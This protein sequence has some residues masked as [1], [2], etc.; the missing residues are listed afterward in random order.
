MLEFVLGIAQ[1]VLADVIRDMI[2]GKLSTAG[3]TEIEK[4]VAHRLL[5]LARDQH[6]SDLEEM[7]RE[8]LSEIDIISA[9]DPD[10][11]VA[12]DGIRLA[13]PPK[14]PLLRRNS[15]ERA[16]TELMIRLRSLSEVVARRREEI[17]ISVK[18][19]AEDPAPGSGP[20]Q[21][22]LQESAFKGW[23][24]PAENPARSGRWGRELAELQDRILQRRTQTGD[25][26][27]Q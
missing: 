8:I 14:R 16:N 4:D 24:L 10:L 12:H 23:S 26:N 6:L 25:D 13:S 2:K 18:S 7:R 27:G 19:T 17:G 15:E 9:R 11:H 20:S 1:S 21:A 22:P 3:R 5:L